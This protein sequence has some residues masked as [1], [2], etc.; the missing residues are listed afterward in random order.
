MSDEAAGAVVFVI[1]VAALA[2]GNAYVLALIPLLL[3]TF[4]MCDVLNHN[5]G[6]HR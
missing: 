3:V 5:E 1:V 2:T 4:A 6:P